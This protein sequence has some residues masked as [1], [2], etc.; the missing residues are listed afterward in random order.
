VGYKVISYRKVSKSFD[1][2]RTW[3]VDEVSFDVHEGET[4][5]LLGSSGCGKT[6]LLKLTNRLLEPSSGI[7]DVD[8]KNISRQD[9]ISLRRKIGYVFQGIGLFPHLTI[10]E[11]ISMVP[12]LLGWPVERRRER[13]HELME[14]IGLDPEDYAHRF[15]GELS[16]GQQQRVGVGRALAA[17]PSYLLL[18]EPFGALDAITRDILQQELLALKERLEKTLLF[19]THD[20]F[21]AMTIGDR[22][23]VLHAGRLEQIGSKEEIL[24]K[25]ATDFVRGLFAKPLEQLST[26]GE[27]L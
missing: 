21:E 1:E 7:I 25:P 4:V 24:N 13:A 16:G 6:T 9:P 5:V 22:I 12:R 11:N 2:G 17:D 20:I 27:L 14:M 19:V 26:F 3:A 8:G 23:A 18:D 10:Q 15:P